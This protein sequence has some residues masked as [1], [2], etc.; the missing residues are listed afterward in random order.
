[1]P[2]GAW[3]YP[4]ARRWGAGPYAPAVPAAVAELALPGVTA[5]VPAARRFVR[6][7]LTAWQLGTLVEQAALVVSELATNAVLHARSELVVRLAT[8]GSGGLRVEVLD[9]SANVPHP[10]SYGEASTTGRGLG[11]VR[12]L[13]R[14]WGVDEQPGR[15]G[16]VVWAELSGAET[17]E[18]PTRTTGQ[19]RGS[20]R[21]AGPHG[22]AGDAG[23][24]AR[25]AA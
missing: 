25:V 14:A 20:V 12:D 10:R 2:S 21:G 24:T 23:V 3:P 16:K 19:G 22:P 1:M 7:T 18:G 15:D 11:I 9:G 13:A 4:G 6:E 5:S 8:D 17:A